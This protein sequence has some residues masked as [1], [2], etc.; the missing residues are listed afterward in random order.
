MN[1]FDTLNSAGQ[2]LPYAKCSRKGCTAEASWQLEWNNPKV[3]SPDR[4]KVW[5]SC[6]EHRE[7]LEDFLASRGFLKNTLA[8]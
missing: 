3:H 4:R 7:Y 6:S 2:D 1:I 8:L 5:L